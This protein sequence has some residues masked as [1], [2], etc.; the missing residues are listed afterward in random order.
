[1]SR[2]RED[3]VQFGFVHALTAALAT[4]GLV[5]VAVAELANG[6]V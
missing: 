4:A 3:L 5:G 2:L 1:M 6:A